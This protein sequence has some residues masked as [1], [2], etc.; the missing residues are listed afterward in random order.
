[1]QE[2]STPLTNVRFTNN[3]QGSIYGYDQTM[4]NSGFT[5]LAKF[6]QRTPIDGLYLAGAW[7]YPGGGFEP[8]MLSGIEAVKCMVEDGVLPI[9]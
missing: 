7:S 5:R 8:V 3:T 4:D 1:M 6:G 9:S 2:A